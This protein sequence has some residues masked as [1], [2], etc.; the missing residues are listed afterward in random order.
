MTNVFTPIGTAIKF[1]NV[2]VNKV[3]KEKR[4]TVKNVGMVYR[5]NKGLYVTGEVNTYL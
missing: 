4:L 5:D 2:T 3:T 1:K